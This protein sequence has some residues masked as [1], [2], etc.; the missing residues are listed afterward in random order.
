[1]NRLKVFALFLLT[2]TVFVGCDI[3]S[4]HPLADGQDIIDKDEILGLWYEDIAEDRLENAKT[5]SLAYDNPDSIYKLLIQPAKY[6]FV[7]RNSGDY[8][9]YGLI[10]TAHDVIDGH[11]KNTTCDYE[12][13]LTRINDKIW[14]SFRIGDGDE[15]RS[16][17]VLGMHTFL[18][19]A[20]GF[21]RVNISD[22]EFEI[23]FISY[24]WFKDMLNKNRM[25][26]DH[27]KLGSGDSQQIVLTAN[28]D[29]LRKLM[30]RIDSIDEAF[31]EE[32]VVLTRTNNHK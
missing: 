7:V 32:T 11:V 20:N 30:S 29:Q 1:M 26:I 18:V 17:Q 22:K 6:E 4:L 14:G 10:K 28:T 31:E 21:A 2:I 8:T 19:K 13:E 3:L 15:V 23:R 5:I 25:R 27:E 12:L 16:S 9:T 24:D